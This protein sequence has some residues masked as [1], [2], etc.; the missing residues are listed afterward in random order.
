MCLTI[1][2]SYKQN[3]WFLKV[4]R[5]LTTHL[6]IVYKLAEQSGLFFFVLNIPLHPQSHEERAKLERACCQEQS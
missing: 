6:H 5:I 2:I 1:L 4:K 3:D